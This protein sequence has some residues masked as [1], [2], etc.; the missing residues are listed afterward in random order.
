MVV[1]RWEKLGRLG[2][3]GDGTQRRTR[4][5]LHFAPA[6]PSCAQISPTSNLSIFRRE[7]SL[8]MY[9]STVTYYVLQHDVAKD[10]QLRRRQGKT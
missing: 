9:W 4:L 2:V 5:G 3:Q 1:N 6:L 7:I 10:L 8:N